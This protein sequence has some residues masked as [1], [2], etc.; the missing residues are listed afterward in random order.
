MKRACF[1]AAI[2]AIV[3]SSAASAESGGVHSDLGLEGGVMRRV[4]TSHPAGDA[5]FGPVV[6][7]HGHVAVLP[8]LR[9]G[10]YFSTDLSPQS[11]TPSYPTRHMYSGGLRAKITP[12]LLRTDTITTWIFT[13]LGYTYA[14]GPSFPLDLTV[15]NGGTVHGFFDGASGHFFEIPLGVGAAWTVRKPWQLFSELGL[16]YGF[17]H[18]GD[19]YDLRTGR[20]SGVGAP[21]LS[22][23][24][25]GYDSFAFFLTVG[26]GLDL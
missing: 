22:I 25:R 13:G 20:A 9:A 3:W 16:R 5:G 6:E 4:L 8:M 2:A 11:G 7:L 15:L 19:L 24:P 18:G 14:Y 10:V 23:D 17:G 21:D 1:A 12:P 26:V